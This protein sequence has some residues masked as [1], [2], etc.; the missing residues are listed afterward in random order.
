MFESF[1]AVPAHFTVEFLGFLV[2][3]GGAILSF[4]RADLVPG[5]TSN[6]LSAAVG[7]GALA[8]A[9]VLHG[10]S[11]GGAETDGTRILIGLEA[12]GLAFIF[13]GVVGSLKSTSAAAV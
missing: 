10:G 12:V 11:F 2:F 8:A 13:V 5:E 6:R 7:F 3:A 9:Q 1:V 4:S